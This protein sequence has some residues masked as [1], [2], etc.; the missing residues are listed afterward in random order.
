MTL[1]KLAFIL[2]GVALIGA[3]WWSAT[4]NAKAA[5]W[6]DTRGVIAMSEHRQATDGDN[7]SVRI[8]FDY[9]VA[10]QKHRGTTVSYA[11]LPSQSDEKAALVARY[12]VGREVQVYYDPADPGRAVLER[13][14]S[15]AW[16]AAA[17]MGVV[18]V[19]VGLFKDL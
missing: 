7:G 18:L 12:P 16:M 19:A 9:E 13:A 2:C 4:M 1:I 11:G 10:G 17:L 5:D 15:R 8:E 6:P 14:P 3:A